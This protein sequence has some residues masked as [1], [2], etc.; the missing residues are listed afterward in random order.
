MSRRSGLPRWL[1]VLLA[2]CGLILLSPLLVLI[3]ALV[4][5]TSKGPV[6]FSQRRVGAA[7]RM[8]VIRKFRT[9][10][11]RSGGPK[12]TARDDARMTAV[13][14]V[15]RKLKL[16][17]L[18]E[19]WNVVRGDMALVGPRPEVPDYVDWADPISR[20]VLRVRPGITD[21]MTLRLRNEEELMA[22]VVSDREAFYRTRLRPFKL[23]G[24]KTYL[25]TRSWLSD[26]LVL[27]RSVAAVIIP[28]LAV[29]P[30]VRDIEES[31]REPRPD[32]A[33]AGARDVFKT[34]VRYRRWFVGLFE[35][36]LVVLAHWLA[37]RLRFDGE[38]PAHEAAIF[39]KVLPWIVGLRL[40]A[41]VP[42]RL[43]EGYWRYASIRDLQH[44]VGAVAS[45]SVALYAL[46]RLAYDNGYPR[47]VFVIDAVLLVV[48]L[49][50]VRLM[51]RV[52]REWWRPVKNAK[53]MLIFGAGDAGAMIVRE[54]INSPD[55]PY[56][57]VGFID[58]DPAKAGLSIHGVPVL[59]TREDLPTI[60]KQSGPSEVLIAG[61]RANVA[62][63]RSMV[64]SL[65]PYKVTIK[66]LPN[67]RDL[68]DGTVQV[69][70]V[71]TLAIEDLL[72]RATVGLDPRPAR[73]LLEGKRVMV[74]G[75][76]GSIGSELCRQVASARPA[77]LILFERYENSLYTIAKDLAD[78]SHRVGVHPVLGDVTDRGRLDAV[79]EEH[80]PHIV[81]HAAAHK[82]VPLMETNPCEA[83][84]NNV[85]GT[86]LVAAAAE[87]HGADR[88]VLI[89]SDK[90]VNPSSVMGATKRID[91]LIVQAYSARKRTS[92]ITVRF[93]NVL[94][95]SGSVVPRF[96]EQ[97]Q[98]GG[99]VTVTHPDMR[100]YFML[101]S[102]AVTLVLHAAA[103][104]RN[105]GT[106]VL[107]MGEQISVLELARNLIQLA[108]FIPEKEIPI[109]MIGLRPGEKLY[110]EL[111]GEDEKVDPGSL[112]E[113]M[114][115]RTSR[116]ING[117]SLAAQLSTLEALALRGDTQA[118]MAQLCQ[119]VP[120]FRRAGHA[121]GSVSSAAPV[122][123]VHHTEVS[124]PS[125]GG[126][127]VRR[128]PSR[129][130]QERIQKQ[131]TNER[132]HR[133]DDCDWHGWLL[134]ADSRAAISV[135]MREE[136][137]TVDLASIDSA[138]ASERRR[139]S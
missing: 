103:T 132:L 86:E 74:T 9:M 43:Y 17:E 27:A 4:K 137:D 126:A 138:L 110:E 113:I 139:A 116:T 42:F 109:Q 73:R 81:F 71:R 3:A 79:M 120:N 108:G 31:E 112:Q 69:S 134:P 117:E 95:S 22:G 89:S 77:S 51:S 65:A 38:V 15:L 78:R 1:E 118:M 115:V 23:Q 93:G 91:E 30:S 28:K 129:T 80:R 64:L 47:S 119:I 85:I 87:R 33:D 34:L 18:P 36:G 124:C 127:R 114:E 97:I 72:P 122:A 133:C 68:L 53:R 100:R 76:G 83:V 128:I 25:A 121:P 35:A 16:D 8:F 56:V 96:L 123:A 66:T 49:G 52:A 135:I 61:P 13:G 102:E 136:L 101:T 24:Y 6:L 45:S 54:M 20:S 21:P 19:L 82:H 39:F 40:L 44:I 10:A 92:F 55:H 67:I 41:F 50:G 60:M 37:L 2:G 12:V 7:G 29:P 5:L 98:A 58:D 59:G 26:V 48:L 94:G 125:C 131:F 130:A 111:I 106:Y 11:V 90:A 14:R 105:G 32:H 57:A 104:G 62:A 46:V 84:K 63:V 75:A 99:P 70:Q 88:F 107:D